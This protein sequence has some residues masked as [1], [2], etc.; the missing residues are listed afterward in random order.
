MPSRI[1]QARLTADAKVNEECAKAIVAKK[2]AVEV[3]TEAAGA[4]AEGAAE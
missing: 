4:P 1:E 2:V 3:A